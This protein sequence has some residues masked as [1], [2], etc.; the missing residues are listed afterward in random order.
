MYK[1]VAGTVI[2]IIFILTYVTL[3]I[4]KFNSFFHQNRLQFLMFIF[5]YILSNILV[6]TLLTINLLKKPKDINDST[7]MFFL[8]IAVC[9]LPFIVS[10]FGGIAS[11]NINQSIAGV[12]M[13]LNILTMPFYLISLIELG[14][15]LSV[16]PEANKLKTTGIYSFS[17]H[18][19]YSCYIFWYVM[20]ILICQ[21]WVIL[22]VSAIQISM[23]IIR[24]KQEE[25]ILARNFP[26]YEEYKAKV[27]WF[28]RNLF[29]EEKKLPA[30]L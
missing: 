29:Y 22:L 24:A 19:L 15:S 4:T 6:A 2:N 3:N 1:R 18:P 20:Q 10:F 23:Q 5:P 26:E 28:G 27:L 25:K 13:L 30:Q 17:R 16:L 11:A 12:G 7:L 14:S 8:C 21:T 9:N